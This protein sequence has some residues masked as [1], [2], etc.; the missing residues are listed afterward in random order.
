MLPDYAGACIANLV[1][2]LIRAEPGPTPS[3]L[4][5]SARHADQIGPARPRRPGLGAAHAPAGLAPTLSGGRRDRAPHH[6]GRPD[7][8]GLR[9]DLD[10]HGA[11]AERPRAARLP[12]GPRR[13][14]PQRPPLDAGQS[15][16]PATSA[17]RS[18]P[19]SSSPASSFAGCR[20]AGAGGVAAAN[21]AEP[22]SPPPTSANSPLHGYRVP[23]SLPL[24][25][26]RLLRQGEPFVYAY[27][28]G[29]DKVAHASG[30]GELYDA[31]LGRRRPPGGRPGR[32]APLGRGAG[33]HGR[34]WPD[35]RGPPARTARA[36]A[37]GHG[38]TSSPARAASAGCTPGPAPPP[39]CRGGRGRALRRHHL[40][41]EHATSS[42]TRACSAD[43]SPR[44]LLAR[45]GDV[46]LIP[47]APIAF[48]DPADTGE[49]RLLEPA[50]FADR[51]RDARPLGGPGRRWQ[52]L[53]MDT[54][55]ARPPTDSTDAP[56]RPEVLDPRPTWATR[57]RPE[58]DAPTRRPARA[59]TRPAK[60]DGPRASRSSSR[61]R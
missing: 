50:R 1:P 27:Y 46:A 28:D 33:G 56:L 36:R 21:S 45:L 57:P 11:P 13:R 49:S 52:H 12:A 3:W 34:P 15:A 20:P 43:P 60:A 53:T 41:D 9:P 26:G 32:R 24:E 7:H 61:P 58:P 16:R 18:R 6:L 19:A 44:R 2:A 22:G 17:A 54:D 25:V 5:A 30:L 59:A 42:S 55:T 38:R 47:H 35:R 40:G 51:G 4:P 48:V 23:S 37:H 14:D 10:H 29:I 31:E 8:H 39:T